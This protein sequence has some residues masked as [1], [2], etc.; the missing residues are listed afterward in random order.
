MTKSQKPY[1]TQKS[2]GTQQAA[3]RGR[4]GWR[5]Y[6]NRFGGLPLLTS[7]LAGVAVVAVLVLLNRP[8]STTPDQP[9]ELI[10]H[11][12]TRGLIEGK[13]DAPV[14]IVIF[15][16]FKCPH[17]GN[18]FRTTEQDLRREFV[19]TGTASMQFHNYAFLGEQSVRA[20]EAAVCAADQGFFWE[21][22]DVLFQRLSTSGGDADLFSSHR[23]KDYAKE[24]SAAWA[25]EDPSRPFD[26]SAFGSC[27]DS[28]ATAGIVQQQSSEAQDLGVQSTPSFLINGRMLVGDQPI[29]AFREA[30]RQAQGVVE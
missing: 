29:D 6:A 20:A 17:C 13:S 26:T 18:F 5:G 27:V 2:R 1:R 14:R 21:Y 22:H 10:R 23:L 30:I 4:G 19:E 7:L 9:Y 12:E 8:A 28:R 3:A 24:M 16:D 15:A 25:T 11:T